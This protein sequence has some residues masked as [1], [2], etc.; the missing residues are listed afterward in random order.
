ML[1]LAAG[2]DSACVAALRIT[3]KQHTLDDI[4]D[5]SLLIEG[6]FI[7]RAEVAV[8]LPV[9]EYLP[10]AVMPGGVVERLGREGLILMGKRVSM[11]EVSGYCTTGKKVR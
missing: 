5:V 3:A 7:G 4:Q 10:E 1:I 2:A 8:A 6:D 9:I 11:R